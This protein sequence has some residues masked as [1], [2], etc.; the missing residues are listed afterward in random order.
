MIAFFAFTIIAEC[1]TSGFL[2]ATLEPHL[3]QL[4]LSPLQLG[5]VF[6]INGGAYALSAPLWGK[7]S[8]KLLSPRLLVLIGSIIVSMSFLL[9]GPAPFI[10]PW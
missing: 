8:D 4:N 1:I 5:F 2:Q 9:V 7:L 10:P 6:V 3:R